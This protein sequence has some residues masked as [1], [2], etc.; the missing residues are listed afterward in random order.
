MIDCLQAYEEIFDGRKDYSEAYREI[1][2]DAPWKN[3]PV[4]NLRPSRDQR[5]NIP[6]IRTEQEARIP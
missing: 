1:L 5:D 2:E 6:G 3:M 4:R